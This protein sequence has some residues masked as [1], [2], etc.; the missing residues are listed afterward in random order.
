MY[1][2]RPLL[3]LTMMSIFGLI[4]F[5]QPGY[6][7]KRV[8]S[9]CNHTRLARFLR[10]RSANNV[11]SS[12]SGRGLVLLARK[13]IFACGVP[14]VRIHHAKAEEFDYD[15]KTATSTAAISTI[16]LSTWMFNGG[17]RKKIQNNNLKSPTL[18]VLL[19]L[20]LADTYVVGFMVCIGRDL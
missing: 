16:E 7:S 9:H 20:Y 3:H 18:S 11:T 15:N 1:L 12:W 5:R 19:R 14:L 10:G 17:R 4:H 13:P 6:S 2:S 8:S